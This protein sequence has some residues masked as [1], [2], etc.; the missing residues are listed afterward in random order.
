MTQ[1]K[2]AMVAYMNKCTKVGNDHSTP[3]ST[4]GV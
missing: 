2:M 3:F 1:L 4:R